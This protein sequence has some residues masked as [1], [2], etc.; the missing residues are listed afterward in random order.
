VALKTS[1]DSEIGWFLRR[2]KMG[3]S[4]GES[5][6]AILTAHKGPLLYFRPERSDGGC[7]Y[8]DILGLSPISWEGALFIFAKYCGITSFPQF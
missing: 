6:L 2:R 3:I 4:K 8:A 7:S 1:F 5:P